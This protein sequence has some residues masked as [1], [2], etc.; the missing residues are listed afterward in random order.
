[1]SMMY[2]ERYSDENLLIWLWLVMT[3]GAAN[4]RFW[5]MSDRFDSV[6]EFADAVADGRIDEM[7]DREREAAADI[8][9]PQVKRFAESC[10]KR[11]IKIVCYESADYPERLRWIPNPPPVLF[12]KG[13]IRSL[14][15]PALIA[16]VGTRKPTEYSLMIT[17]R[18]CTQLARAGVTVVSGFESGI[19]IAANKAAANSGMPTAAVCGR[20]V[21]DQRSNNP[22]TSALER[23]GVLLSEI[24]DSNDFSYVR[25]EYRNRILCGLSDGV[26]FVECSSESQGLNNAAHA[27]VLGRPIFVVPPADITDR[28]YFGQRD[29][30]RSGAIPVFDAN[31]IL[32]NLHNAGKAKELLLL[33]FEN[34][35]IK[36]HQ[37]KQHKHKIP[38]NNFKKVQ[39]SDSK[40]LH[41]SELS[42][43]IDMSMLNERQKEVVRLLKNGEQHLNVIS[44][45]LDMPVHVLINELMR[46]QMA[47]LVEELPGRLYRLKR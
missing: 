11:G 45:K 39:K 16:V 19:D 24:S 30:M 32:K 28:R 23:S 40:D 36:T 26:L 29:L 2:T 42:V 9:M 10:F 15:S 12:Y 3:L 14:D 25:Y 21:G 17:E 7:T 47:S 20:G 18:I 37:K 5:K 41:K 33:D 46:M 4:Y 27:R 8:D 22:L 38:T 43:T 1:M 34:D 13:D 31:D 44:E 6:H 35:P